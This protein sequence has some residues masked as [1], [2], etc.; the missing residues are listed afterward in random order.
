MLSADLDLPWKLGRKDLTEPTTETSPT[1]R[2]H[3]K[4]LGLLWVRKQTS[5]RV[6]SW[7]FACILPVWWELTVRAYLNFTVDSRRPH[8]TAL[9]L[10]LPV[11]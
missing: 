10:L 3:L 8:M 11:T 7:A 4:L 2:R 9:P 1:G 6:E 5:E